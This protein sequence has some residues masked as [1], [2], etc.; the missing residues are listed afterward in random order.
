MMIRIKK[1]EKCSAPPS[2]RGGGKNSPARFR[3]IR[4]FMRWCNR[5]LRR[6][7]SGSAVKYYRP[8][9]VIAGCDGNNILYR[10]WRES[11]DATGG[12]K[13]IKQKCLP[14]G[15]A[16]V[17]VPAHEHSPDKPETQNAKLKI[18]R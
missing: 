11:A 9:A 7:L 3:K 12:G 1:F 16:L 2:S 15:K 10:Q 13:A 14:E 5:A 8:G 17:V 18:Q 4:R 6:K